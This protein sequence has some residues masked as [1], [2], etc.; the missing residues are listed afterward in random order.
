MSSRTLVRILHQD[1]RFHPY[2]IHITHKLIE[3]DKASHVNFHRQFLDI[4]N[5]DEGVLDVL[6][7]SDEAHFHLSSYINKQNFRYWSNN[8]P[9]QLH[10]KPL[11]SEKVTVWCGVSMF[12]VIRPYFFEEN[13]QA[14][15]MDSE[16]CC[17]MLQ[18]FLATELQR[19]SQRVRNV[20]FQQDG[21]TAHMERQSMTFLKGMFPGRLLFPVGYLKSK[22][23]ATCPHSM[24]ELKDCIT[25]GTGTIN[26]ALLQ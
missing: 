12:G 20:R 14:V 1:L 15:T 3:Q 4:V 16:C 26:G 18:T 5:N 11:H 8:N 19:M 21:A 17:T 7:M 10:K 9:I 23:Y 22:A 6:I 2:K 25:E 24:Q 13:N